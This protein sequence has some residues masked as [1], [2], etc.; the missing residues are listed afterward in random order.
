MEKKHSETLRVLQDTEAKEARASNKEAM[1]EEAK[2]E[3]ESEKLS[4]LTMK[5]DTA[6]L[7]VT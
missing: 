3:L 4:V 2:T 1:I 5:K 7:Q 6:N